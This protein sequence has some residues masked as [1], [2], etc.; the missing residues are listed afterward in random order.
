MTLWRCGP[1][2]MVLKVLFAQKVIIPPFHTVNIKANASVKGHRMKVHVLMEPAL[3]PQL[4]A[5]VV[6][7]A[8]YG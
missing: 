8:T 5:T 4:P 3:S 2:W 7:I 6:P 1:S